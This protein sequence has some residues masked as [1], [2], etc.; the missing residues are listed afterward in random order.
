MNYQSCWYLF[1]KPFTFFTGLFFCSFILAG[2]SSSVTYLLLF[3]LAYPVIVL[4]RLHILSEENRV[5]L[6]E[7]VSEWIVYLPGIP[8][9][10]KR[11]ALLNAAFKTTAALHQFYLRA[12]FSKLILHISIFYVLYADVKNAEH[13]WY[14]MLAAIIAGCVLL[15]GL[16][17][18]LMALYNVVRCQYQVCAVESDTIWYEAEFKGK[19]GLSV[20]WSMV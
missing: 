5:V 14:V 16:R 19:P 18:T 3:G 7:R 4:M 8:V 15:N 6:R 11:S 20:L 1:S 17:S 9:Q 12:L 10:E 13:V 2:I